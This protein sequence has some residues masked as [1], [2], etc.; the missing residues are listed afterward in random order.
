VGVAYLN[1]FSHD[2]FG[3][4]LAQSMRTDGVVLAQ[5]NALPAPTSLA[6][7]RPNA[8]GKLRYS[9][10]RQGVAD[11]AITAEDLNA[12]CRFY[13]N[14]QMVYVGCLALDSE[15]ACHY[16]PWLEAQK[17]Q[18]KRI[19]IDANLRPQVMPNLESYRANVMAALSLADI[20]KVSDE[21]LLHL[22]GA[23]SDGQ[24]YDEKDAEHL[25]LSLALDILVFTQGAKGARVWWRDAT[26]GHRPQSVHAV[27]T[28]D[29]SVVD[30]VGAGDCFFAGFIASLLHAPH[31]VPQAMFRAVAS[32]SL[33]IQQRG[34]QPPTKDE[35]DKWMESNSIHLS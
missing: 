12:L 23:R 26:D 6:L 31:D 13:D 21:D 15:D 2:D 7:V 17:A 25:F 11:R 3:L 5:T 9:F 29:I 35:L 28:A 19:V 18:G 30:T 33:N 16:M 32:A 34:C 1:P 4:A 14:A 10:Y 20:V 8:D 24:S 22:L 27:D